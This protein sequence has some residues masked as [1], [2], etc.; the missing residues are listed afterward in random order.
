MRHVGTET[1]TRLIQNNETYTNGNIENGKC[2]D[3]QCT[4]LL[5]MMVASREAISEP[6]AGI[7]AMQS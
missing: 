7:H 3:V 4:A 1:Y 2:I 5:L 6:G